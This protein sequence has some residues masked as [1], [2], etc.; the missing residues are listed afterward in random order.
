VDPEFA[1]DT[2]IVFD[3]PAACSIEEA[4]DIASNPGEKV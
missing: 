3:A 2:H 4:P 1:G